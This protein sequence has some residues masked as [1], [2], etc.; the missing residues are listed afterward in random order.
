[1]SNHEQPSNPTYRIL[2]DFESMKGTA[3]QG[4][5]HASYDH[6]V[7]LFGEP[8]QGDDDKVDANWIIET[9]CGIGTIYNYKDGKAWL[10]SSERE[11]RDITFWHV[12][13]RDETAYQAIIGIVRGNV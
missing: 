7:T 9:G 3:R 10:G 4:Y 6:L 2:H 11:V 8:L 13:G 12:G 1:M 5:L